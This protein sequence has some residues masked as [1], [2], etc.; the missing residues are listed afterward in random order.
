MKVVRLIGLGIAALALLGVTWLVHALWTQR[1]IPAATLEA[2]YGGGAS[3][4]I[5]VDG[6]RM[7][8]R[9]E[10]Q[11]PVVLLLHANFSNLLDWE[12]WARALSD[13][14]RVV[15][16]DMPSHGLTGP[17]PT[18]DYT[19]ERTLALTEAFIDAIGIDKLS[20]AGTSLGGT[21][22]IHYTSRHPDRVERLILLSPGSLEG[23]E[24]RARGGVPRA[25]YVL[26][27]ILPRSLPRFMLRSGFGDPDQV[28][29]ALIDRWHDLWLREGQREAQ[30]DRLSQYKAGDIE[31]LIRSVRVP[32]LLLWGELNTTAVFSQSK[33]F[34]E[35]LSGTP[36]LTFISYPQLGH[37][38]LQEDG[39]RIARDVR[40]W[41]DAPATGMYVASHSREQALL[42]SAESPQFCIEMQRRM[43][44]TVLTGRNELFDDMAAFRHSKPSIRPFNIYQVVTYAGDRPIRVSCKM[45]TAAHL[46]DEYGEEAA[47]AQTSCPDMTRALQS[48]AEQALRAAND[49]AA[50]DRVAAFVVDANEPFVTGRSYLAPYPLSYR[51]ADGRV[52]L[53]SM[54]L[55]QDYDSWVTPLL[56]K[57]VQGQSYCHWPTVEYLTALATGAI[58]PGGVLTTEDGAAVTPTQP[59]AE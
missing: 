38:A 55:F 31:A 5:L 44:G 14:Y 23:K 59:V 2:R 40:A 1:D 49:T 11:G 30:L 41:L 32:V 27:Y 9:D 51:A 48:Q 42:P 15:R 24:R 47:G 7:H 4:F 19:L 12:P 46:R 34:I 17:D 28:P 13:R 8:Y 33:I 29:E 6:V 25:G 54:G 22:A 56:P 10:G 53:N 43:A 26:K 3:R 16:F 20:I 35:L 21:I 50:A 18:G 58:E 52:H 39:A 36:S 45:K 57:I 37:M